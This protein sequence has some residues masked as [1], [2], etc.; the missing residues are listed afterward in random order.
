MKF[1]P[2]LTDAALLD[3]RL[4]TSLIAALRDGNPHAYEFIVETY[5]DRA[6]RIAFAL[7][8]DKTTVATV[9][10]LAFQCLWDKRA[11]IPDGASIQAHL[12]KYIRDIINAS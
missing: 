3:M 1:K 9:V 7:A 8:K 5:F 10:S 11:S 6:Y 2:P 4:R 12:T